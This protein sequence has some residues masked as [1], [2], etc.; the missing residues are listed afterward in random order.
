ML[1]F[2]LCCRGAKQGNR[3]HGTYAGDLLHLVGKF[4]Y[5]NDRPIVIVETFHVVHI[6]LEKSILLT[7]HFRCHAYVLLMIF[8]NQLI[9][10]A[11]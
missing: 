5:T 6:H 1:D 11:F 3:I 4:I 8:T 7:L 9:V 2:C 10:P